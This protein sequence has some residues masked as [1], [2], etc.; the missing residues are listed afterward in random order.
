[1]SKHLTQLEVI[2]LT[3]DYSIFKRMRGNRSID[4]INVKRLVA[5]MMIAYEWTLVI[6]NEFMEIVDGQHRVEACKRLGLEV[7][8]IQIAGLRLKD[9]QRYNSNQ[10]TWSKMEYAISF[11]EAGIKSYQ[12]LLEFMREYPDFNISSAENMLTDTFDGAN[13]L[14]ERILNADGKATGRVK[15]FQHGLLEISMEDKV[16]GYEIVAEIIKYKEFFPKFNSRVFVNT[17]ISLLR[18]KGFDN[19][20][21]IAQIQKYPTMLQQCATVKQYKLMLQDI[22]NM[23]KQVNNRV[24]LYV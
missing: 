2:K 18:Y 8:Y 10:K 23:K 11:A 4:E 14:S 1:M 24:P 15:A 7:R 20:R 12:I 9:V 3:K 17:I 6:C 16:R 22:Y 19:D 5:S 13:E 21:M